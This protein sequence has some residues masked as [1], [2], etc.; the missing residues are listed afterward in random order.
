MFP[1]SSKMADYNQV[2]LRLMLIKI[3]QLLI[4]LIQVLLNLKI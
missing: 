3:S 2:Q 4:E 1:E